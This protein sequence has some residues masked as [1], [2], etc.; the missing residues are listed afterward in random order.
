MHW[1]WEDISNGSA[2]D[3][4]CA[5]GLCSSELFGQGALEP[6]L[7]VMRQR[8][9]LRV[10]INFDGL[11][12]GV[13]HDLAVLAA[14]QVS[15]ELLGK[16]R[17]QFPVQEL[18]KTSNY[19]LADHDLILSGSAGSAARGLAGAL[20]ANAISPPGPK[21]PSSWPSLRWR[22]PPHRARQR[23]CET[24]AP[25][26]GSSHSVSFPAPAWRNGF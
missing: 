6:F 20:A 1:E 8:Q 19:L 11:A 24:A 21:G 15:L 22:N 23:P 12:R 2:S 18:A 25:A 13:D 7:H 3:S 17:R 10:A 14:H 16:V 5:S 4:L 26:S 9:R